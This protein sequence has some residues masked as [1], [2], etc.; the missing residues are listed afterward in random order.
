MIKLKDVTAGY[1]GFEII[2]DIDISFEKGQYNKH[3]RKEW[4]W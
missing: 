1:N 4:L 3:Y 2:K